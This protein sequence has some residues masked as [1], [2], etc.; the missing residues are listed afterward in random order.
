MSLHD[1]ERLTTSELVLQPPVAFLVHPVIWSDVFKVVE[2]PLETPG[3][4]ILA[5]SRRRHSACDKR[6]LRGAS[7]DSTFQLEF[8]TIPVEVG[9]AQVFNASSAKVGSGYML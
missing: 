3:T 8:S 4:P 6:L 1:V 9:L 7:V 5:W 2:E